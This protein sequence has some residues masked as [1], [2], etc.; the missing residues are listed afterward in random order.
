MNSSVMD[1]GLNT[2]KTTA[3]KM[4][5][6]SYYA[7]GDSYATVQANTLVSVSMVANDYTIT[8]SNGAPRVLGTSAK[9]AQ[10]TASALGTP[11]LHVAF[12]DGVSQVIWVT[13]EVTNQPI[14]AGDAINFPAVTVSIVQP[15]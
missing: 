5:L 15:V 13:D 11:D 10:A 12:T 1:N 14:H 6:L 8:G 9:S 4:L 2:I 3:S 7:L